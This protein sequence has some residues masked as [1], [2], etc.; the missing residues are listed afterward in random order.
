MIRIL[1]HTWMAGLVAV[2]AGCT[3]PLRFGQELQT[4]GR[5]G[6]TQWEVYD[7]YAQLYKAQVFLNIVRLVEYGEAPLHFEFSDI[8]ATIT[9]KAGVSSGFEFFDSPAGVAGIA[10][11]VVVPTADTNVKFTP[12]LSASRDVV[13]QA[14]AML[15]GRENWVYDWYY[16][17]ADQYKGDKRFSFYEPIGALGN[18]G[19]RLALWYRGKRYGARDSFGEKGQFK[20]ADGA[21][22]TLQP[23]PEEELGSLTAIL[24]FM[25][26]SNPRIVTGSQASIGDL[27]FTP[28][29]ANA[30]VWRLIPKE[31]FAIRVKEKRAEP[32]S[33]AEKK[34]KEFYELVDQV[35]NQGG[36]FFITFP[37]Q[38]FGSDYSAVWLSYLSLSDDFEWE[39]VLVDPD[40]ESAF[41]NA[42]KRFMNVGE[43]RRLAAMRFVLKES[44]N[45]INLSRAARTIARTAGRSA[46]PTQE[47]LLERINDTLQRL[48]VQGR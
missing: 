10:G 2:L 17:V 30:N 48:E 19:G 44:P 47:Q 18:N 40:N 41:Q 29:A 13:V 14:K 20:K 28:D 39:F 43:E 46:E 35:L 45:R 37:V 15:V 8:T 12:S 7:A 22:D 6:L 38:E 9:D 32:L 26:N 11:A 36:E 42:Y 27:L 5:A 4:G 24:S 3:S 33:A 1:R 31:R 25:R 21:L 23:T 16:T 34:R